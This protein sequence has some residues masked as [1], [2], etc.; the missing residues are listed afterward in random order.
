MRMACDGNTI[1]LRKGD[2]ACGYC[3]GRGAAAAA[4]PTRLNRRVDCEI[5]VWMRD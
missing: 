5:A 1:T 4:R 3:H 2:Q